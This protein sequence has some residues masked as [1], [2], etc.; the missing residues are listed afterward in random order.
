MRLRGHADNQQR[1]GLWRQHVLV[2]ARSIDIGAGAGHIDSEA[3][4]S[5]RAV[6]DEQRTVC[7]RKRGQLRQR[8]R[9]A[10]RRQ[11]VRHGKHLVAGRGVGKCVRK[12]GHYVRDGI[13]GRRR[14]GGPRDG[15]VHGVDARDGAERGVV[16]P[17]GSCSGVLL[18]SHKDSVLCADPA[19]LNEARGHGAQREGRALNERDLARHDVQKDGRLGAH[20]L[21]ARNG[22]S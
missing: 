21:H 6:D 17:A 19:A 7:V 10:R 11:H 13:R 9:Y 20:G 8:Q 15:H 2:R 14:G 4:G 3:A 16:S 5:L 1:R 18:V 22:S 12:G